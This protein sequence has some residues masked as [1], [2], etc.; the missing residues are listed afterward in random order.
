MKIEGWVV[1]DIENDQIHDDEFNWS[2]DTG[3]TPITWIGYLSFIGKESCEKYIK[4]ITEE[5]NW[6][7]LRLEPR[8]A[9]LTVEE[10]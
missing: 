4:K 5:L 3:V 1:W 2:Y 7:T 6:G 10:E 9:T 8:K